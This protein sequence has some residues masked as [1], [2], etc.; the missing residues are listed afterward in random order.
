MIR[1]RI[2]FFGTPDFA[3]PSLLAII[4][5]VH[6]VVCV[7]VQPNAKDSP[8][9][10]VAA[11]HQIPVLKPDKISNHADGLASY[12]PDVIVTC[13]FGQIL[14]QNIL[15]LAPIINVHGSLLPKY[16]GAAPIQW[17]IINGERESGVTIARTELGLDRGEI[18]KQKKVEIGDDETAGELFKRLSVIGAELLIDVLNKNQFIGAAQDDAA[19]TFAPILTKESSFIDFRKNALTIVNFVRGHNPLPAARMTLNGETVKVHKASVFENE[20]HS[21]KILCKCGD[22]ILISIDELQPPNRR[23]MTAKEYLLGRHQNEI[24]L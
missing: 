10:R 1:L 15:D 9:E 18:L 7:V 20:E 22:G 3:V 16:R 24:H 4:N 12:K 8:V 17:A 23:K 6:E 21:Y 14:R 13:A 2:A 11:E 19:A 5:S